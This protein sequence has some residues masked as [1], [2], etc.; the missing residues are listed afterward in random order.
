MQYKPHPYQIEATRRIVEQ[1]QLALFLEMGLGKT[2]CT[3][4]AIDE[5]MYNRFEVSKVLVVAPLRVAEDTWSRECEKWD[6]L[7]HL[8]ISKVLGSEAKRKKALK[9]KAD[10]YVIN[11]ENIAWLVDAYGQHW[12]FDMLVIDELSSFKNEVSLRFMALSKI[13]R[14]FALRVVGL[15]GTPAPN[16][17]TDLWAQMFLI[18]LGERLG[19][20]YE[21]YIQRYFD[22]GRTIERNGKRIVISHTCTKE[23]QQRIHKQIEDVAVS[24]KAKDWLTL[25]ERIDRTVSVQLSDPLMERYREMED[26]LSVSFGQ[27]TVSLK[28]AMALPNK[29]LQLCNGAMY[30]EDGGVKEIHDQKLKALEELVEA[31][32]GHPVL[33]FY[34]Y[35][36]DL[37]RIMKRLKSFGPR[38]LQFS[39]DIAKWNRGEIPILLA[40]PASAGHGLNLQAGGH[41]IVWFGLTWSLELYEQA[42]ARLH[43]QGQEQSVI[44]HHIIAEGTIEETVLHALRNKADIQNT[45]MDA[46]KA[47]IQRKEPIAT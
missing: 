13:R 45:L 9:A 28:D 30:T 41:I 40:H 10:I 7:K 4:T 18:D 31:A 14:H 47:K 12:P 17:L 16:G 42:N 19:D 11:R 15:T 39:E 5:L 27:D 1:E 37:E 8:K 46:I 25:P 26:K 44:I 34:S 24:M 38:A 3:L 6:H 2:V 32:N 23:N 21:D 43:R 36:H 22:E 29:L 20:D 35:R 33:V